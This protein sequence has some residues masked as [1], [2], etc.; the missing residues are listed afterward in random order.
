[1][2]GKLKKK[3]IQTDKTL[4][5][6]CFDTI[7]LRD[8]SPKSIWDEWFAE[9]S[10]YCSISTEKLKSIWYCSVQVTKR[11]VKCEEPTFFDYVKD[12]FK[13]IMSVTC[14]DVTLE[15][16]YDDILHRMVEV[17]LRHCYVNAEI[18]DLIMEVQENKKHV[19]CVSD[20]YLPQNS[21]ERIL[22]S[23][24]VHVNEI[25]VSSD[26]GKRKSS[27]KLY[28]E[29]A[30]HLN[31]T[32]QDI[33]MIGDNRRSDYCIPK[34]M[35][36]ESYH[37]KQSYFAD[38]ILSKQLNEIYLEHLRVKQPFAN[39]CFSLY[40]FCERL[41]QD[42]TERGIKN[43]WFFSREG[44]CLKSLFD[45]Y[46]LMESDSH[47]FTHYLYVSRLS[48]Y[49][50]ALKDIEEEDF[51]SLK[52]QYCSLSAAL[53]LKNLGIY[54]LVSKKIKISE[55][56][57]N[58]FWRSDDFKNLKSNSTFQ[59]VY[60]DERL[61]KREEILRYFM[62]QG[63]TDNDNSIAIVDI[64]WKGTI[65]DNV[66]KIIKKDVYGYY[67]GLCG[68]VEVSKG[69]MKKGLVFSDFPLKS[70]YYDLYNVNYRMLERVLYASHGS[71]CSYEGGNPI[72]EYQSP[73]EQALYM[74]VQ[75]TQKLIKISIER[76]HKLFQE[77]ECA[78][79][80]H[81]AFLSR[82]H[83]KFLLQ[84]NRE[85]CRQEIFMDNNQKMNP[86]DMKK[87]L[88]LFLQIKMMGRLLKERNLYS[89]FNKLIRR[90]CALHLY[91]VAKL[92]SSFALRFV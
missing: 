50:P 1:M 63:L 20:F 65:Q 78:S 42:L 28:K 56:L 18:R 64:G 82:Y 66:S 58:D 5:V 80:R 2:L 79:L 17:E 48:T 14:M 76:I 73:T 9:V 41:Y 16:F 6:D 55:N 11:R 31:L 60:N 10:E 39:Y 53:F 40:L 46:L 52:K 49:L 68:D 27:G 69:N 71:C 12:F 26:Y 21:I 83:K 89:F 90:L 19:Y 47:I 92:V 70:P 13:R 23:L 84:I 72:L 51:S 37:Y 30:S 75:E 45:K 67:Y 15:S 57:V 8:C 33:I 3:I 34:K 35:G 86:G 62:S 77:N 7:V 24:S 81:I 25:F 4:F 54:E 22:N 32:P 61:K 44:A 91:P 85:K 29:V 87:D 88:D 43:V 59:A 36:I 74:Q 38:E